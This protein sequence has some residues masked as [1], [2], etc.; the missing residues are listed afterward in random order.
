ML[1]NMKMAQVY[2]CK[3]KHYDNRLAENVH[4]YNNFKEIKCMAWERILL[5]ENIRLRS[6]ENSFNRTYYILGQIF[7]FITKF[8]PY[9]VILVLL[10]S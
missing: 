6:S 7:L 9:I 8:T 2:G 5:D 10:M 4:M 1:I 3:L